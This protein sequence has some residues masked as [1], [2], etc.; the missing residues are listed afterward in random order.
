MSM[1]TLIQSLNGMQDPITLFVHVL[2]LLLN[3][4]GTEAG[5]Y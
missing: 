3:V 1:P 5:L 2:S 4:L